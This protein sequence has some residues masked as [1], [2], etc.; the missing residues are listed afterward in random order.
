VHCEVSNG[1]LCASFLDITA[2]TARS[3]KA[4]RSMTTVDIP[5]TLAAKVKDAQDQ[6]SVPAPSAPSPPT[7]SVDTV[8]PG[9]AAPRL[10]SGRGEQGAFSSQAL[11]H[12]HDARFPRN[13]YVLV[14]AVICV[15]VGLGVVGAV[16]WRLRTA[17]S[18]AALAA[19]RRL[20]P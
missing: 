16:Q 15:V 5:L 11:V 13:A 20:Q 3:P 18:K 1:D 7:A 14:V 12:E 6:G 8:Q 10:A 9:D 19:A 17:K 2:R 4:L